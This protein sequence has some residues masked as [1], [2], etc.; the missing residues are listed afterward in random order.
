MQ[1]KQVLKQQEG[2]AIRGAGGGGTSKVSKGG[3]PDLLD[4]SEQAL[5]HL[6]AATGDEYSAVRVKTC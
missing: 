1:E 3:W 5:S 6:G 4:F 2:D